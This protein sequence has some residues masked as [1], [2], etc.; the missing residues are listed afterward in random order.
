MQQSGYYAVELLDLVQAL[1]IVGPV[2]G[3]HI[4]IDVLELL[5]K[6]LMELVNKSVFDVAADLLSVLSVA[7]TNSEKVET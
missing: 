5:G 7:I 1:L 6:S 2:F 4:C 3:H